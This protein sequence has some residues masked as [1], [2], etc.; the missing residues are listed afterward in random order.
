VTGRLRAPVNLARLTHRVSSVV[1]KPSRFGG[2]RPAAGLWPVRSPTRPRSGVDA[3]ARHHRDTPS[4][5]TTSTRNADLRLQ[6]A[7]KRKRAGPQG[8]APTGAGGKPEP[9]GKHPPTARA[10]VGACSWR[11]CW[12]CPALNTFADT[13]MSGAPIRLG[14]R[15]CGG[16]V[17]IRAASRRRTERDCRIPNARAIRVTMSPDLGSARCRSRWAFSRR[18][19][20]R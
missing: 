11:R 12:T 8:L 13:L 9:V 2:G 4:S 7:K 17:R 5:D 18:T 15:S 1:H 6:P 19:R 3:A 16:N 10:A 14:C 20:R